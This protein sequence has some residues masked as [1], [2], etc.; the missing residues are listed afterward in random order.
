[1]GKTSL[2]RFE[3][4]QQA[5]Y[6][7]VREADTTDS[8]A[9]RSD[10]CAV[11]VAWGTVLG[12]CLLTLMRRP[13]FMVHGVSSVTS[14]DH[15]VVVLMPRRQPHDETTR[16]RASGPVEESQRTVD[17]VWGS[18][19]SGECCKRGKRMLER[20]RR[21]MVGYRQRIKEDKLLRNV[22]S[23]LSPSNDENVCRVHFS[24][25]VGGVYCKQGE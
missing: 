9:C 23:D 2:A 12:G 16:M 11:Q 21:S 4:Q 7:S 17:F 25:A 6:C 10:E 14:V 13:N 5:C 18:E 24:C 22:W 15:E 20:V 8:I 19:W 1:M 3:P